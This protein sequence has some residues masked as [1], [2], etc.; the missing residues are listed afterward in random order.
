MDQL[1]LDTADGCQHAR[2]F[3]YDGLY[4]LALS[5]AHLAGCD[6]PATVT[7]RG[8]C[9]C[10]HQREKRFCAE[11]G[12]VR[13]PDAVWRCRECGEAGHDCPIIHI[14]RIEDQ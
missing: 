13:P 6:E 12:Q 1:A 11:H 3:Y 8:R 5:L 10:G 14:E 4:P 9:E 7:M 2:G